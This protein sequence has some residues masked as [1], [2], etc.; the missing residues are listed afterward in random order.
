MSASQSRAV[1]SNDALHKVSDERNKLKEHIRCNELMTIGQ[2]HGA[3]TYTGDPISVTL[4]D[5][6]LATD[7]HSIGLR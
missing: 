4:E 5:C 6:H 2:L 3:P 7:S 1:A